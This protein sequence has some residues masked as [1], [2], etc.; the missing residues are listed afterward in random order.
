MTTKT[1]EELNREIEEVWGDLKDPTE[2]DVFD[3]LGEIMGEETAE[4]PVMGVLDTMGV[5][6][7]K[8]VQMMEESGLLSTADA[9][10]AILPDIVRLSVAL[11]MIVG[12]EHQ[13]RGYSL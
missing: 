2:G 10:R 4:G 1:P 8:T 11:G 12:R 7:V 6:F 5:P 3:R 13:R 9:I